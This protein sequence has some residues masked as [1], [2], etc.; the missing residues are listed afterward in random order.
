MFYS[1]FNSG[2]FEPVYDFGDGT[3]YWHLQIV[4]GISP[5]REREEAKLM[6]AAPVTS[7]SRIPATKY[8]VQESVDTGRM[9][10]DGLPIME[11]KTV[12]RPLRD[13]AATRTAGGLP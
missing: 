9:D 1:L 12:Q 3:F 7:R 10:A 13:I 5:S 2:P 8:A 4:G 6:D 11:T